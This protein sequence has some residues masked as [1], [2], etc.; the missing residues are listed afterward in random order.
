MEPVASET[1]PRRSQCTNQAAPNSAGH[2]R[3]CHCAVHTGHSYNSSSGNCSLGDTLT[4]SV[5]RQSGD[6]GN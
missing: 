6:Q 1:R 5:M 4:W 2:Q 3:C